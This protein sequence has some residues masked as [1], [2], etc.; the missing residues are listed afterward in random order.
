MVPDKTR[1]GALRHPQKSQ[2]H[3]QAV[4]RALADPTRR[5]ILGLLRVSGHS[6][7][8]LAGNFPISRPAISKHLRLLRSAGLVVSHRRGAARICELNAQPLRAVNEWL[9]DYQRFWQ[10]S[11]RRL[12]QFVEEN[13]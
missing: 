13:P 5:R 1:R 2:A 9:H 12:K 8:E 11:L 3:G 10:G 4:F 7:G 6:V